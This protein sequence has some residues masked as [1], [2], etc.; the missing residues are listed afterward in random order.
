[1]SS[2]SDLFDELVEKAVETSRRGNADKCLQRLGRYFSRPLWP[3]PSKGNNRLQQVVAKPLSVDA[4]QGLVAADPEGN[5]LAV[6]PLR[7]IGCGRGVRW[8]G[9]CEA[10]HRSPDNGCL[11]MSVCT[12]GRIVRL[13]PEKDFIK[14]WGDINLDELAD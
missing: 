12:G 8:V 3:V 4:V 10:P 11:V 13:V 2:T 6:A 1:M 9:C 5:A 7:V 14:Y